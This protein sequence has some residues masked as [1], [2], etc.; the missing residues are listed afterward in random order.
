M[1]WW[2]FTNHLFFLRCVP[3]F[4]LLLVTS[5]VGSCVHYVHPV[6]DW[7][8]PVDLQM[9]DDSLKG[10]R[11]KLSCV[12]RKDPGLIVEVDDD[13]SESGPCVD[14]GEALAAAG[15]TMDQEK[16]D[17]IVQHKELY[18]EQDNCK[19]GWIPFYFT[20]SFWPCRGDSTSHASLVVHM[21]KTG[22]TKEWPMAITEQTYFGIGSLGLMLLDMQKDPSRDEYRKQLATNFMTFVR[23]KVYTESQKQVPSVEKSPNSLGQEP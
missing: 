21:V 17:I 19:F 4:A 5:L 9:Y 23:N 1:N 3:K 13:S 11:I 2:R 15:A 7:A 10:F 20:L 22:Q 14:I 6:G 18:K 8:E 12:S 16:F